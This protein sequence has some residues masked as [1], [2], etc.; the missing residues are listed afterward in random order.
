MNILQEVLPTEA[1]KTRSKIYVAGD[2]LLGLCYVRVETSKGL[3]P[4]L[5]AQKA[6][7]SREIDR[8]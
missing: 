7:C 6:I 4:R 5:V 3:I 8:Y 2:W 1:S